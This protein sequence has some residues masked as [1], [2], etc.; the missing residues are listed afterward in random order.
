MLGLLT[1]LT[2]SHSSFLCSQADVLVCICMAV[3]C[4]VSASLFGSLCGQFLSWHRGRGAGQTSAGSWGAAPPWVWGWQPVLSSITAAIR[5]QLKRSELEHI[6]FLVLHEARTVE[7]WGQTAS[8]FLSQNPSHSWLLTE[9]TS[10]QPSAKHTS[11]MFPILSSFGD[12]PHVSFLSYLL[13]IRCPGIWS[14]V[15][16]GQ[17]PGFSIPS[18]QVTAPLWSLQTETPTSQLLWTRLLES[19]GILSHCHNTRGSD[20]FLLKL[21]QREGGWADAEC[22]LGVYL[23]S[24]AGNRNSVILQGFKM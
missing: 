18:P 3:P 24:W 20:T 7:P 2:F 15:S 19:W 12:R 23:K 9:L 16:F 22:M 11:S 14:D 5:G 10:Q 21:P 4:L 17:L 1:E 6:A 8:S 13:E